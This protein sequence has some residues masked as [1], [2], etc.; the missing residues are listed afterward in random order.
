MKKLLVLGWVMVWVASG[1]LTT[2]ARLHAQSV[3]PAVKPTASERMAGD[4]RLAVVH[5]PSDGSLVVGGTRWV[6]S[7]CGRLPRADL[8]RLTARGAPQWRLGHAELVEAVGSLDARYVI[9]T[10]I[11]DLARDPLL[12]DVVVAVQTWTLWQPSPDG[13]WPR[14]ATESASPTVR[15]G[16]VIARVGTD[17]AITADA[18]LDGPPDGLPVDL[19][20]AC[21]ALRAL[22]RAERS[23]VSI[24][25]DGS[26]AVTRW[27]RTLHRRAGGE[28]GAVTITRLT[29]DLALAFDKA[30]AP[31]PPPCLGVLETGMVSVQPQ[32]G[33]RWLEGSVDD[34]HGTDGCFYRFD[35]GASPSM[36]IANLLLKFRVEPDTPTKS[37]LLFPIRL[38]HIGGPVLVEGQLQ[39]NDDA[40]CAHLSSWVPTHS[41]ASTPEGLVDGT[42]RT[43]AGQPPACFVHID[44]PQDDDLDLPPGA[45]VVRMR[46]S[47]VPNQRVG[48]EQTGGPCEETDLDFCTCNG[49]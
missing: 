33:T 39:V 17:G 26:L 41:V 37:K 5:D 8:R 20:T 42:L 48:N 14:P 49:V 28:R 24:E 18:A 23:E 4:E 46:L 3:M 10:A 38:E 25:D 6:A 12:G 47:V 45:M 13:A 27:Q 35:S 19:L 30:I 11:H 21:D 15:A 7:P 32:L 16:V 34:L 1:G 2:S 9:G 31:T 29:S 44:D 40:A 43:K 22:P 36:G